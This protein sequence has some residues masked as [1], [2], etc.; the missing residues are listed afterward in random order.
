MVLLSGPQFL[1]FVEYLLLCGLPERPV[2]VFRVRC[3]GVSFQAVG[4]KL[5]DTPSLGKVLG[6]SGWV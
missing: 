3:L 6:K 5:S 1:V 4:A 2:P